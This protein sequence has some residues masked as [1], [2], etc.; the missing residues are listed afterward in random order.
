LL[1][2]D[3]PLSQ[4]EERLSL[5]GIFAQ[6]TVAGQLIEVSPP[7]LSLVGAGERNRS[8]ES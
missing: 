6:M 3:V 8:A 1:R 4:L 7:R 5:L 2:L